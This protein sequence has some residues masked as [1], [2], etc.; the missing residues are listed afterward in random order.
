ML[1][2]TAPSLLSK[3]TRLFNIHLPCAPKSL[4]CFLDQNPINSS[5]GSTRVSEFVLG[6]A[7]SL[8]QE[9][10]FWDRVSTI[11]P[12]M[13]LKLQYFSLHLPGSRVTGVYYHPSSKLISCFCYI[14]LFLVLTACSCDV[15][16]PQP[17]FLFIQ[18]IFIFTPAKLLNE[19]VYVL[20]H[21]HTLDRDGTG[22]IIKTGKVLTV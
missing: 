6:N 13:I 7:P 21:L 18:F 1:L 14:M 19:P 20:L 15:P 4:C 8:V 3:C 11:H 22:H 17:P 2:H 12:K 10:F 5:T 16:K 9:H